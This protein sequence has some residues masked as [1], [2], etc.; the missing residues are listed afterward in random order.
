[1]EHDI[2]IYVDNSGRGRD[3]HPGT[4]EAPVMTADE[5]FRKL[6]PSWPRRAEIIFAATG[7]PY[8]I[9]T[10]SVYLGTPTGPD[11]SSLVIRGGYQDLF[12][13]TAEGGSGDKI[14]TTLEQSADDLIGAVLTR[15]SGVGSPIGTSISIRGNTTGR[16]SEILLQQ[17]IGPVA[18]GDTFKVQRPAVTLKPTRDLHLTSHD[19]RTPN[20][21]LVGIKIA[22][23]EG[24]TVVLLNVRAHCE[25]C[26]FAFQGTGGQ[27]HTNARIQG[28]L[29]EATRIPELDGRRSQAGVYI[30]GTGLLNVFSVVRNGVLGGHLTFKDIAVRV[31]QG[32]MLVPH[33]LEAFRAQIQILAGGSAL[34]QP[35]PDTR[36]SSWG[37][38]TNK[39]RIRNVPGV[40]GDGL[41]ISNGGSLNSPIGPIHL[42]ISGCG[43]DGVRLDT[44]ATAS[45]G[46]PGGA[47]GLISSSP[48][49]KFGM[50]VRNASRALIGTDTTLRGGPG[51]GDVTLDDEVPAHRWS[52]I[53][54]MAPLSNAGLSL[55]RV[56]K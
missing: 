54:L 33:S 12:T 34:G 43:R 39:A 2:Q 14:I 7:T 47:S 15:S 9:T 30:H 27:I 24:V 56:N 50:N 19:G 22:P 16:G 18:A 28:G 26:E 44:G 32:G 55:V 48:N 46:P 51:A 1:M 25:T 45:F 17:S 6:P 20:L 5:A 40:D 49:T 3:T 4:E 53:T 31:S 36:Q 41:R 23:A 10:G 13:L 11:A 52:E 21:N 38:A 42:D 29:E 8:E 35:H 37:T